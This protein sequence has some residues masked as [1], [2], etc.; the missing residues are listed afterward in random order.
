MS[1]RHGISRYSIPSPIISHS[2]HVWRVLWTSDQ[3]VIQLFSFCSLTFPNSLSPISFITSDPF[4]PLFRCL[5]P[6]SFPLSQTIAF[7]TAAIR[8][9]PKNQK[10]DWEERNMAHRRQFR[11]GIQSRYKE[12]VG[13]RTGFRGKQK[14]NKPY[15]IVTRSPNISLDGHKHPWSLGHRNRQTLYGISTHCKDR[16]DWYSRRTDF[17]S[18]PDVVFSNPVPSRNWQRIQ[19]R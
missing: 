13:G 6:R 8:N 1:R 14:K 16:K 4:A 12:T 10:E 3:L 9:H 7:G 15:T 2:F 19:W 11:G 5:L 18:L 17:S